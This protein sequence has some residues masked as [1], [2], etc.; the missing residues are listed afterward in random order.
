VSAT[1]NLLR[2]GV[3]ELNVHTEELFKSAIPVK[4]PPQPLKLLIL[5]ASR[6]GQVVARNEI[7]QQLWAGETFVDFEH[8]VN[9]CVNQIRTALGDNPDRPLYIETLPRRGYRFV[10]PVVS[11]MVHAPQPK[12]IESDS[13]ERSRLP[14][15]IGGRTKAAAAVAEVTAVDHPAIAPDVRTAAEPVTEVAAAQQIRFR[16]SR[17]RLAWIGVAALVVAAGGGGLY[18]RWRRHQATALPIKGKIVVAEFDNKTSD[19]VFDGTLRLGLTKDLLQSP[20]LELISD[21]RIAE[22][23]SLM[24]QPKNAR[25]TPELAREVCIR[26]GSAATLEG[27]VASFGQDYVVGLR[28]VNC[29]TGDELAVEQ[30]TVDSKEKILPELADSAS[31]IRH[32]LGESLVS[33]QEHNGS[34]QSVTTSSLEALKAYSDGATATDHGDYKAAIAL[35]QRAIDLDSNFASAY[36]A[37]GAA[38]GSIGLS[39]RGSQYVRKAYD[40]R[41]RV[42]DRERLVIET[43]YEDNITGNTEAA[44]NAYQLWMK[45]YPDNLDAP[46]ELAND[47]TVLGDYGYALALYKKVVSAYPR[48]ALSYSNLAAGYMYLDRLD[49]VHAT[50]QEAAAHHLDPPAM[51]LILYETEFLQNDVAAMQR[52][53]AALMGKPGWE[54]QIYEIESD[55]A[56]YA[57]QFSK[58]RELTANAADSAGRANEKDPAAVYKAEAAV[59]EALVG[60]V[61]IA[62]AEAR[63]A[64]KLST[65]RDAAAISAV[66]LALSG[67]VVEAKRVA[68]DLNQRFP[69]NTVVQFNYLPTIRAGIALRSS[70]PKKA[71]EALAPATAYELGTIQGSANF[72]LYPVYMRGEAYLALH[73]GV[74]SAAEFQKVLDHPGVVVNEPIG[75]LAH[76]GLARAYALNRDTINAKVAYQ[77]FLTLWQDADPDIP[78][79]KQAKVEYLKLR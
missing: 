42:S 58:A 79:Y 70:N 11:K 23:M 56:A 68:D 55:S 66:A 41:E 18:W 62:K 4:L 57:G 60:N 15:L 72:M 63:A 22:T 71:I 25:F 35:F 10:A 14:V 2:F 75:A 46:T 20:F 28:A 30:L 9:K 29:H 16:W 12:V 67:D 13:G 61:E 44:R 45:V 31:K 54:D 3:F 21:A 36:M 32:A 17:A 6:A 33:V 69:E 59:R 65:S 19:S 37:L 8:G 50:A 48:S 1:Q 78:I 51:H 74:A 34:L 38:Y 40:L 27:S 7:Q 24:G 5:L 47:D 73:Q 52:D 77:D 39:D 64:L 53:K 26:T 43:F 49:E 76:L